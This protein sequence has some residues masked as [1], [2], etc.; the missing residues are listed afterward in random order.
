M[1][2]DSV[3]TKLNNASVAASAT[4]GS[5]AN[6]TVEAAALDSFGTLAHHGIA[7]VGRAHE[8][9]GNGDKSREGEANL[10]V[11]A[12]TIRRNSMKASISNHA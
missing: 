6:D 12:E 5:F 4:R 2:E 7:E 10:E 9:P 11:H 8:S 3:L 1:L